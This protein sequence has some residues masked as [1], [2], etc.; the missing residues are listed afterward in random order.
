[1]DIS[2][3]YVI[4]SLGKKVICIKI[5]GFPMEGTIVSQRC[6]SFFSLEGFSTK[7]PFNATLGQGL[8]ESANL[9]TAADFDLTGSFLCRSSLTRVIRADISIEIDF[10]DLTLY[11]LCIDKRF[12]IQSNLPRTE[13]TFVKI[14]R[15]KP[16]ECGVNYPFELYSTYS[17]EHSVGLGVYR[18]LRCDFERRTGQANLSFVYLEDCAPSGTCILKRFSSEIG[19]LNLANVFR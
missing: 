5:A 13:S 19:R 18:L 6:Q 10:S 12:I 9:V 1:M 4:E 11:P 17:S 3:A 15:T 7:I 8:L 14:V 2:C 16:M